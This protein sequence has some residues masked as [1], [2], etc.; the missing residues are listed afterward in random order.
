ML[1]IADLSINLGLN[2]VQD[3]NSSFILVIFQTQ[4]IFL[5]YLCYFLYLGGYIERSFTSIL[6]IVFSN[7]SQQSSYC[8]KL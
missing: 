3:I 8:L 7:C 5:Y 2:S 6:M 4:E 1:Y